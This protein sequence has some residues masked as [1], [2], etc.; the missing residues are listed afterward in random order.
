MFLTI[1]WSI[2]L[3]FNN[4]IMKIYIKNKKIYIVKLLIVL[5]IYSFA[6]NTTIEIFLNLK[7]LY[8]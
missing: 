2:K 7:K 6:N 1:L 4:Y 3:C 5:I 8:I